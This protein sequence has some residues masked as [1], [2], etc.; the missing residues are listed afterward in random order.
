MFRTSN[1]LSV[2]LPEINASEL[3][4]K[5][6]RWQRSRAP[7]NAYLTDWLCISALCTWVLTLLANQP[8]SLT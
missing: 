7:L 3:R 4:Q 2:A 8:S 6:Q 1:A 5:L